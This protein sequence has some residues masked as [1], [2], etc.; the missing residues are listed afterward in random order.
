MAVKEIELSSVATPR[1]KLRSRA[2]PVEPEEFTKKRKKLLSRAKGDKKLPKKKGSAKSIERVRAP[3]DLDEKKPKN[4]EKRLEK[5]RK[6]I[7]GE[8]VNGADTDDE[9]LRELMRMYTE[10]TTIAQILEARIKTTSTSRDVY[11]L[12][13]TY[14]QLR[15]VIA[16]IR[17]LRDVGS[18]AL[19][20]REELLIPFVQSLAQ[21]TLTVRGELVADLTRSLGPESKELV[22][23][24]VKS[25]FSRYAAAMQRSYEEAVDRLHVVIGS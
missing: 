18:V 17:A 13:Q 10:L 15:E 21:D 11:P 23:S 22:S 7:E 14:S 19:R 5:M 4:L 25:V 3:V 24:L 2:K 6:E 20:V 8:L 9:Q 16:D 1:P 12:L